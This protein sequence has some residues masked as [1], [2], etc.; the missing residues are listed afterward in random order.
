MDIAAFTLLLNFQI[1]S[2]IVE[3]PKACDFLVCKLLI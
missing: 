2:E 1:D 3:K